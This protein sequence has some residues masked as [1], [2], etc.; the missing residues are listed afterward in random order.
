MSHCRS[1]G[2]KN[3]LEFCLDTNLTFWCTLIGVLETYRAENAFYISIALQEKKKVS[4]A[5]KGIK[6]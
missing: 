3:F 4:D 2:I 5:K 1:E 6:L